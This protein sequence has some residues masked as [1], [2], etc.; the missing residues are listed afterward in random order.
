[1]LAPVLKMPPI[2]ERFF[3]E[4]VIQ[5][6]THHPR[7]PAWMTE[8]LATDWRHLNNAILERGQTDFDT[9]YNGLPPEDKVV[10][11]CRQY[12]QTMWPAVFFFSIS[13][14]HALALARCWAGSF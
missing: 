14:R 11:Y 9:P 10:I 5:P 3:D 7:T 2:I 6:F 4:H 8:V 12:M 13:A 1:M